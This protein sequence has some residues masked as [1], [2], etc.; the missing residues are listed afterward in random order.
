MADFKAA[1]VVSAVPAPPE[2][3]TVYF[4]RV[5]QGFDIHVTNGVGQ[6]TIY[7]LNLDDRLGDLATKD[8]IK[9]ADIASD[10]AI[11]K[12][13]LAS[14]VQESLGKADTAV[15]GDDS[16]LSDARPASDVSAWAKAAQKP[17]Y[18]AAEISGLA[19]LLEGKAD[20]DDR[21]FV[22]IPAN[23]RSAAYTLVAS[24]AGKSID[25]AS[26]V[27]VPRNIFSV[28]DVVTITNTGSGSVTITPAAS[29]TLRM[30]GTADSGA[31]KL[32]EYGVATARMV[33]ANNWR[34][35][36]AGLEKA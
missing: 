30:A 1:K 32:G 23:A 2:P 12:S 5:G 24:D 34:I 6:P 27:T 20:S 22:S 18:T 4:V 16:R 17:G 33:T 9:D 11:V 14:D 35:A 3:D 13:K 28:G 21:R 36:G 15:Q 26:A 29:V 25:T 19:A 7:N 8:T 10:A 31:M